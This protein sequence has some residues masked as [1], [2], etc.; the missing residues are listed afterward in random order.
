[1]MSPNDG[2][3]PSRLELDRY[4]T[5]ELSAQERADLEAR[6]DDRA[7]AHL[8]AIEL[9]AAARRPAPDWSELRRRAAEAPADAAAPPPAND[10][11]GFARWRPLIAVAVAAVALLIAAPVLLQGPERGTGITIKAPEALSL[12]QREGEVLEPY[13]PGTALGEGD[14]IGFKVTHQGHRSVV[15]MSV[16]GN[17]T[18][19][20]FYPES[21][22]APEP[23]PKEGKIALPGSVIL[24]GAPGP[25]VFV[26]VFDTPVP[27]AREALQ[28]TY[29]AGGHA[30]VTDWARSA[31][32][33]VAVE[34]PRK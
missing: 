11:R 6:L 25:E 27:A 8:D 14:T 17:G 26:A 4:A 23:L 24:D 31:E 22:E 1:M 10:T 34:V 5:G 3:R 32:G 16:D 33:V 30:G 18:V 19:S 12:Y 9:A 21:G 15:V 2:Q 7:R 28:R 29:Q 20:V 13:E